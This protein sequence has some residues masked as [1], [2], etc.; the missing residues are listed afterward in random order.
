MWPRINLPGRPVPVSVIVRVSLGDPVKC[1]ICGIEAKQVRLVRDHNHSTGFIRGWLCSTC[2]SWLGVFESFKRNNTSSSRFVRGARYGK[3]LGG[4][5]KTKHQ[6]WFEKYGK[7]ID[8]HLRSNTG[9]LYRPP[10][11]Y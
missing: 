9:V 4:K 1:A 2:N 11:G 7:Q 6:V 3:C 10:R 5:V 8:L